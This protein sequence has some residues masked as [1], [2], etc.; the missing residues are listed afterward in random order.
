[1]FDP[2]IVPHSVNCLMAKLVNGALSQV[3]NEDQLPDPLH[4]PTLVLTQEGKP[5]QVGRI[6]KETTVRSQDQR[7]MLQTITYRFP[8][9]YWR[10]KIRKGERIGQVRSLE[11]PSNSGGTV[12]QGRQSPPSNLGTYTTHVTSTLRNTHSNTPPLLTPPPHRFGSPDI[13]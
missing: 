1:M 9:N 3:T 12:H 7:K 11:S 10:N 8:S 2:V 5:R 6:A 4:G 13:L